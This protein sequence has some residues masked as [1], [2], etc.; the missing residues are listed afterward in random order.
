[1]SSIARPVAR[2]VSRSV[3]AGQGVD[4]GYLIRSMFAGGEQGFAYDIN[5][6]STMF[7]DAAGTVPVTGVGQTVGLIKDKSG[8]GNHAY[9]TAS[10]SRPLLQ[11]NA[12]TGAYYLAFDG[13][14]DFLVTN[15]I[16]FS[17]TNKMTLFNGA[18]KLSDAARGVVAELSAS[19]TDMGK[20]TLTAPDF[21]GQGSYGVILQGLSGSTYYQMQTYASPNSAVISYKL[22]VSGTLRSNNIRSRVNGVLN[23]TGGGG[24][25][26]GIGGGNF[27]NFPLYIGRRAGTLLPFSGHIYSL[28]GVSRIAT[29]AETLELEKALAKLIG[30]IL[31]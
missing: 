17:A 4:L 21:S 8:H 20:F 3:L 13:A 25:N 18:K 24:S 29:D 11:R 5:D 9:Q 30:V 22:D 16:D 31:S 23:Q 7:R 14:D 28:I 2:S 19:A 10:A 6:L 15:S 26:T 27:G 12:T 1:M